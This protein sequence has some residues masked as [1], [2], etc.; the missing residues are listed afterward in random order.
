MDWQHTRCGN[1]SIKQRYS[2]S[3]IENSKV[4]PTSLIWN[5]SILVRVSFLAWEATWGRLDQLERRG[6]RI[7]NRC[8][9]CKGDKETIDP[10]LLHG[11]KTIMLWHLI[12]ALFVIWIMHSTMRTALLGQNVSCVNKKRMKAKRACVYFGQ[13]RKKKIGELFK[14]L[15]KGTK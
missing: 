11:S 6:W 9:L 12:Y 2:S 10:T 15:K 5:P 8:Y 13:F 4:F 3:S 1:F 7:P 14:T